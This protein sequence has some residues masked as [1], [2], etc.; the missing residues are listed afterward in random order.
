[1][2]TSLVNTRSQD[3]AFVASRVARAASHR[4]G[5]GGLFENRLVNTFDPWLHRFSVPSPS[6]AQHRATVNVRW[7]AKSAKY[8][9]TV[10]P[11]G[12]VGL[13]VGY[14]FIHGAL[15]DSLRIFG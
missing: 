6:E 1:M 13:V 9:S 4:G 15:P 10:A 14:F 12:A 5:S 7:A 3:M 11:W 2:G 8:N